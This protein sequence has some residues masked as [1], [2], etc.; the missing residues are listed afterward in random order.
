MKML[1][2]ARYQDPLLIQRVLLSSKTIAIVGLSSNNLRASNFVGFYLQRHGYRII[3]VN[4]REPE[5]L[6]ERS[7]ASLRDVPVAV[8]IVDVFRAP[9][10]LP[11]IAA[12][13]VAIGARCLWCQFTVINE[14]GARIAEDGG[15][16]V[17]MDRCI[18][19]EHARFAGRMHW[20]GF[21]TQRITSVRSSLQ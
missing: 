6:G 4:P 9:A 1:N 5:I 15:L 21:N 3:P 12:E 18:K 2:L 14:E 20:L 13:A 11:A 16:S 8:D 19:V 17:I 10:A 7:Y